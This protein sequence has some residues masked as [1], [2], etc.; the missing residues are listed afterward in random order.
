MLFLDLELVNYRL[1]FIEIGCL[2]IWIDFC[3]EINTKFYIFLFCSTAS[4][5][6]FM[7]FILRYKTDVGFIFLGEYEFYILFSVSFIFFSKST[8]ILSIYWLLI[9]LLVYTRLIFKS[10]AI[11]SFF[12][13]IF[14]VGLVLFRCYILP[15]FYTA[16]ELELVIKL[17]FFF[18]YKPI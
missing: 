4:L 12:F 6:G 17:K 11:F 15:R 18:F 5:Y 1:K 10:I 14:L 13:P 16:R 2:F 3:K 9:F 8:G 7:L